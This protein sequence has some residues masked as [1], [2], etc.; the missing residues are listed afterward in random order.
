MTTSAP[1]P[2]TLTMM[3]ACF[4]LAP[5]VEGEFWP[6]Q[7]RFGPVAAAAPGFRGVLGGPIAN[8]SWLY[9]GGG[10]V[11]PGDN[12]RGYPHPPNPGVD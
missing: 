1:I 11:T 6:A 5:G 12:E 8:S 3:E 10:V 4:T 7:E 2:Q 9:F